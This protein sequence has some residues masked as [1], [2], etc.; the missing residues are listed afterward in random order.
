[1]WFL[2]LLCI[3]LGMVALNVYAIDPDAFSW[4]YMIGLLLM[5]AALVLAEWIGDR[6]EKRGR[7]W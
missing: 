1:M 6:E 5:L 3:F 7:G 4:P 2:R